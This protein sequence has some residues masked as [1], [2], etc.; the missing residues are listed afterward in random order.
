MEN[1]NPFDDENQPMLMRY[2]RLRQYSLWL[3]FMLVLTEWAAVFDPA[4]KA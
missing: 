4:A 1:L 2:D 3:V